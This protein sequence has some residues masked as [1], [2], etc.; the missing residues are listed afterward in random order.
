MKKLKKLSSLSMA[1]LLVCLSLF[2]GSA[3]AVDTTL[4]LASQITRNLFNSYE[5]EDI[6]TYDYIHS[7][8]LKGVDGNEDYILSEREIGGYAI[9]E[10]EHFELLEYSPTDHSPF[11]NIAQEKRFYAGP[12]NYYEGNGNQL[13]NLYSNELFDK[14]ELAPIATEVKQNI[15]LARV[16]RLTKN[17]EAS[18]VESIK[19]NELPP[20]INATISN[21]ATALPKDNEFYDASTYDVKESKYITKSRFFINN[22]FHGEN[23]GFQCGSIAAQLLLAYHN[24]SDDGRILPEQFLES[25]RDIN[26]PYS[27]SMLKTTEAFFNVLV[28]KINGNGTGATIEEL[29]FGIY[30]YLL[31]Y[32]PNL[33]ALSN[34][35]ISVSGY[36][37]SGI[38]NSYH[39]DTIRQTIN[40]DKPIIV[41][42]EYL[43][44]KSDERVGHYI[45]CY[46]SQAIWND[47]GYTN[48][49]IGNFGWKNKN[50]T[51]VWVNESW[52]WGYVRLNLSH[53]HYDQPLNGNPHVVQCSVCNRVETVNQHT[54]SIHENDRNPER[55]VSTCA[56]GHVTQQAHSF[57]DYE[58]FSDVYHLPKCRFC[59]YY[60]IPSGEPPR[61]EYEYYHFYKA[62]SDFCYFCGDDR[63]K[64]NE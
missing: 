10:K 16:E 55:H 1:I 51:H 61:I 27:E 12:I 18:S 4:D 57:I 21:D 59:G 36:D 24:W 54:Y 13:K 7:T 17:E 23:T 38:Q 34:P 47:K 29:K 58:W 63:T 11:C 32:A 6:T 37:F 30:G 42:I 19:E 28:S 35:Q 62:N 20:D 60:T 64:E 50:K 56:C 22:T 40:N 43:D 46:G 2:L 52:V 26:V 48:G 44:S 53:N 5:G 31:Q 15:N 49:F 41:A 9:F 45:V 39:L 14:T 8:Y 33:I 3:K 25:S